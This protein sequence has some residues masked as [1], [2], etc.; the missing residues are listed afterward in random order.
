MKE[1]LTQLF[2][3]R[4]GQPPE[5]LAQA[6]GRVNLIGE[7]TDYN[8]GFVLP[9]AIEHQILMAAS[10]RQDNCLIFYS[11]NLCQEFQDVIKPLPLK[12]AS[13]PWANY[14]IAILE[15]FRL[16]QIKTPGV[17]LAFWGDIPIGAGLASS[18][19]LEVATAIALRSLLQVKINDRE[20]ALL[21][22]AAEHS[23]YIGVQC[24]IMDQF[25]ALFA[26]ANSALFLDCFTL[27]FAT[28]SFPAEQA[29]IIIFDSGVRRELAS[30]EYNQRRLECEEGLSLLRKLL[31]QD[32]P[33][34]R[35]CSLEEFRAV[36]LSLPEKIRHRVRHVISENGR[37]LRSVAALTSA[38]LK[39]FGLL[40]NHS[41][42]S[43]R[44]D[45]E[46]SS[47]ELETIIETAQRTDGVYGARLTGAGFGGCA[48]AVAEP[49]AVNAV[50]KNISKIYLSRHQRSLNAYVSNPANGASVLFTTAL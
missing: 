46:V 5:I 33:T 17:N 25:T 15:Q 9:V 23:T 44:E 12:K 22:Q 13:L 42:Q 21:C 19:A 7:H 26:R 36:E 48:I 31:G 20:L 1:V 10:L 29:K 41:H 11:A 30:S 34:L 40:L 14:I 37:V 38:D 3:E 49:Q 50:I 2:V 6:P 4:F 45:Y 28:V 16:R 39:K 18:A 8:G 27:N 24:G 32:Y 35:H 47:P 43:L